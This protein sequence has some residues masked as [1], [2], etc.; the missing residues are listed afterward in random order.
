VVAT[1]FQSQTGLADTAGAYK[2]EQAVVGQQ[3]ASLSQ[4]LG[5]ANQ[6]GQGSRELGAL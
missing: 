1:E 2:R 3:V 5:A 6:V 4:G